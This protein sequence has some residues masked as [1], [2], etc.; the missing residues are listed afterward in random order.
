MSEKTPAISDDDWSRQE[1]LNALVGHAISL[2]SNM[3]TTIVSIFAILLRT[4]AGKAGLVM[5]SINNIN[6]WLEIV[7][8]LFA[9]DKLF[10]DFSK[11]WN[12]KAERLKR[13]NNGR[14]RLAHH[15]SL[16][17]K[18]KMPAALRPSHLDTRSRS[19]AYQAMTMKEIDQLADDI[20]AMQSDLWDLQIQMVKRKIGLA[21][22]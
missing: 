6:T 1:Q 7:T 14:V 12:K 15:S 18:G 2:W 17:L 22:V 4:E 16:D 8:E 10:S 19:Q 20:A 5:F 3:E 13:M 21:R 11:A 9:R